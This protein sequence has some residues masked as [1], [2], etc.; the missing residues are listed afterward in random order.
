MELLVSFFARKVNF[1][2]RIFTVN[3]TVDASLL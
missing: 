1:D 3:H 2:S